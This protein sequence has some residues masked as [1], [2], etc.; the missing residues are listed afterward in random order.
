VSIRYRLA[1]VIMFATA[2]AVSLGGWIFVTTISDRLHESLHSELQARADAVSQQLQETAPATIVKPGSG[3]DLSDSQ[4]VTAVI[5]RN[6]KTLASTGLRSSGGLLDAGQLAQAVHGT[7]ALEK[8]LPG[9]QSPL[10]I[11]A[12]PASDGKPYVVV[13]GA[14]L[15]T[16]DSAVS[17]VQRAVVVGGSISVLLAGL[18]AWLLAGA[19]LLPVERMR[20][21][22]AEIS[23]LDARVGLEVPRT[24]DEIAALAETLNDLLER[25]HETLRVQRSF[26]AAAGHEL[27][28]PLAILKVELELAGHPG[29]SRDELVAAIEAAAEETDRLVHLAEDLLVLARSDDAS[30]FV[31][32]LQVDLVPVVRGILSAKQIRGDETGVRL[33]LQL[34]DG[35]SLPAFVDVPRIRQAIENI[36][37]N[38]LH[39]A[40]RGST[41]TLRMFSQDG[42]AVV[43]ISDRGPGFDTEF[44]P[45]AFERFSRPDDGRDRD[46]GGAGLGLSI[47]HAIVQGHRGTV[48]IANRPDGGSRVTM[49]VPGADGHPGGCAIAGPITGIGA[50]SDS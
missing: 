13:V 12:E 9:A 15:D 5:N 16:V 38:A 6:G 46:D 48:S 22:A 21:Q 29:R 35:Q 3:P 33:D 26:V 17:Q 2:A 10:L 45:R 39:F 41:V 23:S 37:D 44:L 27:R 43:E 8:R 20:R 28:T 24:H 50:G 40:P 36:I 47:V 42:E 30:D 1:I 19:A 11:L 49:R 25:L 32:P 34:E 4:S 31:R 18:A 14:T 7:V